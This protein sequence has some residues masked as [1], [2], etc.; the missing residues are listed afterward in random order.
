VSTRNST[1]GA[2]KLEQAIDRGDGGEGLA[3][4]GGH[5]H[6]RARVVVRERALEPGDGADLA[7]AQRL[8]GQGRHRRG[9]ASAQRIGPGQPLGE[10]VGPEEVEHLARSR[11]RVEPVGEANHLRRGLEQK[12]QRLTA[13]APLE[14]GVGVALGL[15]FVLGQAL[16]LFVALGLDH[17]DRLAIDDQHVVG[18]AAVGG[19]L[20]HGRAAAGARVEAGLVLHEPAGL[21]ELL[22]DAGACLVF[23]AGHGVRRARS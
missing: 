6:Q 20:T 11:Q 22:V 1:L 18:R 14:G 8:S 23:R 17:P 4:A 19:V 2:G 9:Q 13:L 21:G 15:H 3:G 5:V 7:F 16:A 10:L 12:A